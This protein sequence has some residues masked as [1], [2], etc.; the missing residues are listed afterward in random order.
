KVSH[1]KLDPK[2][3]TPYRPYHTHDEEQKLKPGEVVKVE[4]EVWPTGTVF[5]KGHR[6]QLDIAPTSTGYRVFSAE[7]LKPETNS[8]YTGGNR[9][10]Y[11][12]LPVIPAKQG[13]S[14][15]S[16]APSP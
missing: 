10:S 4:V 7:S 15:I 1:R 12:L 6:I 9:G 5:K 14:T 3:S 11:L 8:I 13:Q 2:L 16:R